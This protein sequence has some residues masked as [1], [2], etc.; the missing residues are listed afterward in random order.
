MGSIIHYD[1]L[2]KAQDK[3]LYCLSQMDT[4]FYLTG[5]TCIHRFYVNKRYS[6]DLDF[7][8]NDNDLFRDYARDVIAQLKSLSSH[9]EIIFDTRDFIRIKLDG[10]LK[11]D[12]VND[13]VYRL[14]RSEKSKEGYKIDNIYNILANKITAVTGRDEPKDIF[15]IFTI[16]N[17]FPISWNTIIEAALKKCFFEKD[18]LIDRLGS[19]PLHL[20][21][22][23]AVIDRAYIDDVKKGISEIVNSIMREC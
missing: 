21:D 7:F 8:C 15:D 18:F 17:N 6:D 19:F 22:N 11:I 20:L 14:G 1:D 2:Y 23:L 3:A 9:Y 16:S 10:M 12:F 13:R 4:A 5:G